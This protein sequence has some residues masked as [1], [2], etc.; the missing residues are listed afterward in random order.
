MSIRGGS[1]FLEFLDH[2]RTRTLEAGDDP[3]IAT[4]SPI[5]VSLAFGS[6]LVRRFSI[7]DV[8]FTKRS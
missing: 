7:P 2:I 5:S 3:Q 4:S 6:G 1:T 8:R